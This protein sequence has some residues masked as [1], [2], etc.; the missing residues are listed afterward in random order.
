MTD[1]FDRIFQKLNNEANPYELGRI[2]VQECTTVS[3]DETGYKSGDFQF[4]NIFE[5]SISNVVS[6]N[7]AA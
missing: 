4:I 7:L 2:I 6:A 3:F 5:N 1:I